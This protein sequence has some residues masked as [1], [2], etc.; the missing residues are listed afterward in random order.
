MRKRIA[1]SITAC[2]LVLGLSAAIYAQD[3]TPSSSSTP[4]LSLGDLARQAKK[5]RDEKDKSSKP[6]AKVITNDDLSSPSPESAGSSLPAGDLAALDQTGLGQTAAKAGVKIPANTS[7]AEQMG[8]L[9]SM[10]DQIDSMDRASLA[11]AALGGNDADFPGRANWEQRL[12]SAKQSFVTQGR[13]LVQ[14][15]QQ[16]QASSQGLAGVQDPNDPRVKALSAQLQELV[17]D[18]SQSSAAFQAVMMEGR[19]LAAQSSGR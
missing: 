18:A 10:L 4:S 6:A 5:Q 15:I 13:S 9:A 2:A 19:D 12:A 11:K 1:I 3:E 17:R 16:L 7:V 8:K 14:R